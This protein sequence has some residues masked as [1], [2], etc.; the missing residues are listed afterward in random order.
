M[1]WKHIPT[2]INVCESSHFTS[3]VLFVLLGFY[4]TDPHKVMHD[5]GAEGK[6]MSSFEHFYR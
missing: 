4:M 2:P 6:M 5:S 1:L 3:A